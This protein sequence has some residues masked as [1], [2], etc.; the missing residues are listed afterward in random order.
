M[1]VWSL[2]TRG[3]DRFFIGVGPNLA[4][5]RATAS[6]RSPSSALQAG[7]PSRASAAECA[8]RHE[9]PSVSPHGGPLLPP[10]ALLHSQG[11]GQTLPGRAAEVGSLPERNPP[12]C[13]VEGD[14]HKSQA[15]AEQGDG[16][17][18]CSGYGVADSGGTMGVHAVEPADSPTRPAGDATTSRPRG[19][20][21]G[22]RPDGG[23]CERRLGETLLLGKDPGGRASGGVGGVEHP[24]SRASA[25]ES[26]PSAQPVL[27]HPPPGGEIPPRQTGLLGP[28]RDHQTVDRLN[29]EASAAP[30]VPLTLSP[31]MQS[32]TE[33]GSAPVSVS[34]PCELP[35]ACHVLL[36]AVLLN[37]DATACYM[38]ASAL[39]LLWSIHLTARQ[40]LGRL[41]P[42]FQQLKAGSAVLLMRSMVW[43]MILGPWAQPNRQHDMHELLVHLMPRLKLPAVGGEWQFRRLEAAG[44]AICEQASTVSPITLDVPEEARGLQHCIQAWHSR[45]YR[46]ALSGH[47]PALICL[48]LSRFRQRLGGAIVKDVQALTDM[49]EVIRLPCFEN[50]SELL[51][52]WIPYEVCAAA[53][54]FG[55]TVHEGHYKALLRSGTKLW[56]TDD[57][58]CAAPLA[59]AQLA[60]L[61]ANTYLI[62]CRLRGL[63]G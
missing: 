3:L 43:T 2:S 39:A 63:E 28:C 34:S 42:L 59:I 54:H 23:A 47:A 14:G 27:Y 21:P 25:L 1:Y 35:S 49:L 5:T 55:P 44:V 31:L 61:S 60:S 32:S 18:E 50:S 12:H 36:R 6:R 62:W 53:P 46:A 30:H 20:S 17:A 7:S 52:R 16:Q 29:T 15:G 8:E 26:H 22:H 33:P 4:A 24:R 9:N 19:D 51:V 48:H 45:H 41:A 13:L 37:H 10:L 38:N 11:M 58:Q 57:N 56:L 40:Q